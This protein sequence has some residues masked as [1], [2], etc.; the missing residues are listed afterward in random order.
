VARC[1]G[2]IPVTADGRGYPT[3]SLSGGPGAALPYV[4]DRGGLLA[5]KGPLLREGGIDSG[6]S[7]NWAE[8][9]P[10]VRLSPAGGGTAHFS[11]VLVLFQ[12]RAAKNL[13]AIKAICRILL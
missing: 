8:T 7:E 4:S 9:R 2:P 11:M 1:G 3:K 5:V 13:V 10:S 6:V 12:R